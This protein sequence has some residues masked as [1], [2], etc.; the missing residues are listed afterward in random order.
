M[1][2]GWKRAARK[3][4]QEQD[5]LQA[6]CDEQRSRIAELEQELAAARQAN[7]TNGR[8]FDYYRGVAGN[9][10]RFSHSISHLADSFEYLT[11]QLGENR[12]HAEQVASA[13]LSNQK[14][15]GE[16]QSK[17]LEMESGLNQASHKVETL[18]GH[19]QEINGIVEL[20]GGIASQTNLLALNAAIEAARAGEAGRGFAVVAG[21]IRSLAEKTALAT[22]DIVRKIGDVQAEIASVNDYIQ[23][24]GRLAQGFSQTTQQA[25][26]AMRTLHGLA[27]TMRRGIQDSS[28]RAG[29]ELANLDE[30]SLKFVVYNRLLGS[31][32][33]TPMQLPSERECRFGRWY[34]GEG[35]RELQ[36]LDFQRIERPHTAVHQQGQAAIDA[37]QAQQLERALTHLEQME[38]ANLEVMRIVA[39]VAEQCGSRAASAMA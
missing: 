5:R 23:L 30:L 39:A 17:A 16:L 22:A 9:L 33:P 27:G 1:L 21:E 19:S 18:A 10:I 11:G 29:I 38:E 6:T 35:S 32:D 28:F 13:A 20:I 12:D 31:D 4:Q 36:G 34:Y 8:Q 14:H 2:F 15:F 7:E 26:S 3:L 25:V 24:Q 37:F